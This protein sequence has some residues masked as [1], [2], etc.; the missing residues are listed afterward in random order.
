MS[1]KERQQPVKVT[2]ALCKCF[3]LILLRIMKMVITA[4]EQMRKLIFTEVKCALFKSLPL[5]RLA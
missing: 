2:R 1:K 5:A 4:I 3:G